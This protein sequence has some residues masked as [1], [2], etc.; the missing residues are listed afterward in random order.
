MKKSFLLLFMVCGILS[1]S[2]EI[3]IKVQRI[4]SPNLLKNPDFET[5]APRVRVCPEFAKAVDCAAA[6]AAKGLGVNVL[7][8]PACA[9][10]DAFVN[11][12]ARGRAFKEQVMRMDALSQDS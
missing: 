2:A 3:T 11:F 5:I 8:S 6:L 4:L 7:L 10:F 12:E 1:A 9:S